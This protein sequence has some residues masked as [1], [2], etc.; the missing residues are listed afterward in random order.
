MTLFLLACTGGATIDLGD[1]A[2]PAKADPTEDSALPSDDTS[3][4]VEPQRLRLA[5][6]GDAGEQQLVVDGDLIQDSRQDEIAAALAGV[7]DEVGC[8]AVLLLGDNFYPDGLETVD[9]ERWDTQF[10]DMYSVD[11]PFWVVLGNHDYGETRDPKGDP[12]RALDPAKA[13]VQLGYTGDSRWTLPA[14]A[15]SQSHEAAVELFFF[16]S[17]PEVWAVDEDAVRG[18]H[19]GNRELADEL[20]ASDAALKLVVAHHPYVSNGRHG[21]AGSYDGHDAPCDTAVWDEVTDP[22][23]G[24]CWKEFVE[25]RICGHA[26]LFL[27]GHDHSLQVL[28]GPEGCFDTAVI[29]GAASKI[30]DP[31]EHPLTDDNPARFQV[32]ETGFVWLSL[33][34]GAVEELVVYGEQ[35]QELYRELGS[36]G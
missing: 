34:E 26:D 6:L 2:P 22:R 29:S 15:W 9:D 31:E 33:C 19:A 32:A 8:D 24:T 11:A 17:T 1:S 4:P 27:S 35:G 28:D 12:A 18:E 10:S 30:H 3:D 20:A 36:C 5:L 16:D 23:A 14:P 21:D 25:E 7:C 13:Q